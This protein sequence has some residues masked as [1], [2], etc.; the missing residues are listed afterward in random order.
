[1]YWTIIFC[2]FS[3]M[4]FVSYSKLLERDYETEKCKPQEFYGTPCF[5]LV[6]MKRKFYARDNN[7]E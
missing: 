6:F 2:G 1:M 4:V 7:E 3:P 5:L